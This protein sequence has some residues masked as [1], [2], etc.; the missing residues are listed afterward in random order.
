MLELSTPVFLNLFFLQE[1]P[2]KLI[3]IQ[4]WLKVIVT[5][6]VK[7]NDDKF[8]LSMLLNYFKMDIFTTSP[9]LATHFTV[10]TSIYL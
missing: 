5:T 7:I 9:L 4:T 10:C 3:L 6:L 8:K 1:V 2:P